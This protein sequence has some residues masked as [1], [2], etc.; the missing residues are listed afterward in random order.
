LIQAGLAFDRALQI[1]ARLL[2]GRAALVTEAVLVRVRDGDSLADAMASQPGAFPR[3]FLAMVH[4]GEQGGIVA[5]VLVRLAEFTARADALRQRVMSAMIYPTIL[6]VVA[7]FAIG[8]VLTIVLPEFEPLFQESGSKL[9]PITRLVMTIGD[10]VRGYWFLAPP[11]ALACT[12]FAK[13][14][15]TQPGVAARV[16]A[17][18]L[19]VPLLGVLIRQLEAARFARTLSALLANGVI[20]ARALVLASGAVGN[21]AIATALAE[22]GE[23]LREG[24][25]LAVPIARIGY[26]PDLVIQLVGVGEESGRLADLLSEAA[27]AL[28]GEVQR[29]LDRLLALLVPA[30][31]LAMG[32][33]IAVIVA[34]V[35]LAMMS[36]NDLAGHD[37]AS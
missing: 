21:R 13:L 35:L 26:M 3:S 27:D 31:T 5:P 8:L 12:F 2:K 18:L 22:V 28:E 29:T 4:A 36:I 10:G 25:G 14:L 32:A 9:P 34:A 30:L 6:A 23:R 11:T 15:L 16:D 24:Q 1:V 33:A 19:R 17:A 20:A 7:T 37:G